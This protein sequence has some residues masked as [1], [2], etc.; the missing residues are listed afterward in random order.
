MV[1][2]RTAAAVKA[3]QSKYPDTLVTLTVRYGGAS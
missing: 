2:A 1:S 3:S